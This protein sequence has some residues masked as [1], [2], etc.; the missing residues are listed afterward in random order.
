M[1]DVDLGIQ[2][3]MF[4]AQVSSR[5]GARGSSPGKIPRAAAN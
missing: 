5:S 4:T 1:A 2:G 3:R